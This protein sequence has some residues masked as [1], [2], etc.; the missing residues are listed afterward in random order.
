M[1]IV[2]REPS[3]VQA[4]ASP[5]GVLLVVARCPYCGKKHRHG[6]AGGYGPR[7]AHCLDPRVRRDYVLT[8][9]PETVN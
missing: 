3:E 4:T 6:L 8:P 2:D 7:S 5:D 1:K 9:A